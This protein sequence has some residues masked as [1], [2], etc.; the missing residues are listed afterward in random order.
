MPNSP[1]W[2]LIFRLTTAAFDDE[3]EKFVRL[4]ILLIT[5]TAATGGLVLLLGP[6]PTAGLGISSL[7]SRTYLRRTLN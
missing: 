3:R 7:A 6:Y 4:L 2:Q 5:I 1:A